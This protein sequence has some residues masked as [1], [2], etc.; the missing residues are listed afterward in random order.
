MQWSAGTISKLGAEIVAVGLELLNQCCGRA[1]PDIQLFQSVVIDEIELNILVPP[2]LAALVV[3]LTQQV[4]FGT[5]VQVG[6]RRDRARIGLGCAGRSRFR[7]VPSQTGIAGRPW[8]R[9]ARSG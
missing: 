9:C 7:I 3:I 8:R 6:G 2:A 5:L 1:Q 4:E